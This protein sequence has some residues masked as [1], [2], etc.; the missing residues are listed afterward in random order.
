MKMKVT[1]IF[2]NQAQASFAAWLG[3]LRGSV[4]RP[5]S[6]GEAPAA[7]QRST[8]RSVAR[9][10]LVGLVAAAAS[11]TV[12]LRG[13]LP[14]LSGRASVPGLSR[15]IEIERDKS[16]IPHIYAESDHDAYFGLGYAHAQDRLW[17]ME[18]SR[19]AG[20]GTL[21]EVFGSKTLENDR[22]F[23]TL[24][25]RRAAAEN[26]EHLDAKTRGI[27][28]AYSEG[29]NAYL[30]GAR[31]LPP[32]FLF[33]RHAPAPWA[34]VDSLVWLKMMAW[35]LS[36]NLWDELL[37]VR[38][39]HRLTQQDAEDLLPPYPGDEARWPPDLDAVVGHLD[40]AAFALLNAAPGERR[41]AS[42][43]TPG[44][45]TVRGPRAANRCSPTILI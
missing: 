45:S 12:A 17:Q 44:S 20:S 8:R 24:G 36:G 4:R 34:P 14:Q 9:W 29:V 30:G 21:S 18:M 26:L 19:R 11:V 37:N 3:R 13:S 5:G 15:P 6:A 39:Q 38:L 1:F 7:P 16:G 2:S 10:G 42:D 32:E 25:I 35:S 43:P 41:R 28:K 27:L 22:F 40:A 33:F 31:I 23:R